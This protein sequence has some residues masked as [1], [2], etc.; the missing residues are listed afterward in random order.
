VTGGLITPHPAMDPD[1]LTE[2]GELP[3]VADYRDVFG[4]LVQDWLGGDASIAFP[5]HA[6]ADL[7]FVA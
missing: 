6:L 4:T 2:D 7:A 5:S 1:N 3:M